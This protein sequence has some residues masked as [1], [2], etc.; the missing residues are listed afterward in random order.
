M[1]YL[2]FPVTFGYLEKT[3]LQGGTPYTHRGIDLGS[4]VGDELRIKGKLIAITGESGLVEGPHTHVQAG[5]D[6]WAQN[7]IDP[8]PYI[9]EP[10]KVVK[11]GNASQW[12][13]YVCIRVGDVNVFYCHLKEAKVK[14]GDDIKEDSMSTEKATQREVDNVFLGVLHRHVDP[15][16]ER[17]YVGKKI[18]DIITSVRHSAEFKEQDRKMRAYDKLVKENAELKKQLGQDA[19]DLEPGLYRVK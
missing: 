19:Q 12:G 14:E 7:T 4:W 11:V 10:G 3:T 13:N 1:E 9:G 17:T 6:E 5:H 18:D 8:A 15:S 16:G 2:G